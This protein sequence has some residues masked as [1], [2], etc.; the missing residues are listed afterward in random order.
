VRLGSTEIEDF[1]SKQKREGDSEAPEA[2]QTL[3]EIPQRA[4][5]PP[6]DPAGVSDLEFASVRGNSLCEVL[7]SSSEAS[8]YYLEPGCKLA[9]SSGSDR[10]SCDEG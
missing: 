8:T 10:A 7:L 2:K 4:P 6:Y 9:R 3:R 5:K 1:R